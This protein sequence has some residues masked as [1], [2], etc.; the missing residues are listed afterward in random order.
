ML[1]NFHTNVHSSVKSIG[2]L[3]QGLWQHARALNPK[4]G[5]GIGL[6]PGVQAEEILM[7]RL[8]RRWFTPIE[9]DRHAQS[10]P[11]YSRTAAAVAAAALVGG[12]AVAIP[13]AAFAGPCTGA[14]APTT[15]QTRCLTAIRIPGN[16]LRSFDISWVNQ[17][18]SEY[19]L[20]DRSNS[21]IDVI[22]TQSNTFARTIGGFVGAKLN[23][24]GAVNNNISGPD[25][26]TA[27]GRWLYAGD[28][29]STLHVIDLEAPAQSATRQIVSTGG[30]SRVDEM[31]L[32]RD[33]T[34]LL[35]ANNADDPPF[36]TLFA[37]NGDNDT[38]SVS[39][40]SRIS[41]DPA[42]VPAGFGL[43]IEQSTWEHETERFYVSIPVIANNP[44]GCNYGQ[45]AGAI[46]CD[47]GMLV[48]DPTTVKAESAELGA[49]DRETKTGVVML[50]GCGPNGITVGP[51]SN[52]L[53]GCTPQNNPSDTTT[54]VINA[55]SKNFVNIA[56]ITGS[57]EVWFNSGD[58]RY[59]TG[60]WRACG[61][62]GGCPAPNGGAVLGVINAGS[63]LLIEKIP[64]SQGTHSV[65]AD[66][67][68]NRIYVPQVAPFAVVG[69][70]GD[71]TSVG[72]GICGS[73]N[74]CVAVYVH[75]SY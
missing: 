22:S 42:I 53:L 13:D 63:N 60:S 43:S 27:H 5:A 37:A 6:A 35:A 69:A 66:P 3:E 54:Q 41:I 8:V 23:S 29:D 68:L 32:T 52:L 65:A 9:F 72:A 56:G 59:Y 49:F 19:Y 36:A 12:A 61:L 14:G 17:G 4:F 25:G 33:G 21:G 16:P 34:L 39:V 58:N 7:N 30:S 11:R 18:R 73:N 1:F 38:S 15:T 2:R 47:G 45:S 62:P 48:I 75:S 50:R 55:W 64:Q 31:A 46:T 24:A 57:D 28:G 26:V 40:I 10:A 71:T 20:S 67:R 51:D 74:G 44:P 70:G